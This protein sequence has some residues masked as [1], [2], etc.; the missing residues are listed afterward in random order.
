[1]LSSA[2]QPP[3]AT[4]EVPGC[5]PPHV[6]FSLLLRRNVFAAAACRAA[7]STSDLWCSRPSGSRYM[8]ASMSRWLNRHVPAVAEFGV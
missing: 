4:G 2:A 5:P 7:G 1:M 3:D 6:T 8:P